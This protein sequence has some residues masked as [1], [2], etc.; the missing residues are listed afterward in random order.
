MRSRVRRQVIAEGRLKGL[1]ERE[2]ARSRT[3]CP[4][5]LLKWETS[6]QPPLVASQGDAS[7]NNPHARSSATLHLPCDEVAHGRVVAHWDRLTGWPRGVAIV[8]A[9]RSPVT[10]RLGRVR[11]HVAFEEDLEARVDWPAYPRRP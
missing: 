4:S 5:I 8:E 7:R 1:N 3:A 2:R 10:M 11:L 9:D 6:R